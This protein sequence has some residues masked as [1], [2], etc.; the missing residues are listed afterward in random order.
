MTALPLVLGIGMT[1]FTG[2][3]LDA[4]LTDMVVDATV[5]ALRDAGATTAHVD[6]GVASY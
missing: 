1:P 4:S 3:R 6:M 2:Q 5:Q